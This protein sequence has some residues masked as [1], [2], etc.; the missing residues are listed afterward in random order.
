MQ[1][2][3]NK[4]YFYDPSVRGYDDDVFKTI[5]GTVELTDNKVRINKGSDSSGAINSTFMFTFGDL[6]CKL[7]VPTVPTSGDE[8]FIGFYTRALGNRNSAYFY[9]SGTNFYARSYSNDSDTAEQTTIA[10]NSD[11]TDTA[12]E[13][14]IIWRVNK[15]EFKIGDLI[16]ATHET[17]IPKQRLM[18]LYSSNNRDDEFDITF[19]EI[20]GAREILFADTVN[21]TP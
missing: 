20:V 17:K 19:I 5:S 16:V 3:N 18:P 6:T 12:T 4:F 13:F 2:S 7:K 15:V 9:I 1:N 8:R 14:K 11:W 21:Y 10:W